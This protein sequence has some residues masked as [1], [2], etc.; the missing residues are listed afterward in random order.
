MKKLSV[1]KQILWYGLGL[2][3]ILALWWVLSVAA[4][5]SLIL[6]D[7]LSVA[8]AFLRLAGT[9]G[10]YLSMLRSMAGILCGYLAGNAAGLLLG[11]LSGLSE[12][13]YAFVKPA[14]TI[15]KTT[16]VASFIILVLIW[17]GKAYTPAF[18]AFLIVL[19]VVWQTVSSGMRSADV[20]L[21]EAAEV[22][23]L[24]AA[25]KIRYVYVP[26]ASSGYVGASLTAMG[27]AWKA[28]VA[29]EVL[30]GGMKTL[31]GNIYSAKIYLE[32]PDLFAWTF[33]VIALSLVIELLTGF[34]LRRLLDRRKQAENGKAS[35][36]SSHASPVE[37]E[38]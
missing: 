3:F 9:A 33:T 32:I 2:A 17:I 36:K 10:F 26:E 16:P 13:I 21:L 11:A 22:F 1:K 37:V 35:S 4:A 7:P 23:R 38:P 25:K 12:R 34:V 31:G 30:A 20:K 28:G 18:T 15:I 5:N 19:P 14:M 6:P 27:F 24:S 29:A 8:K